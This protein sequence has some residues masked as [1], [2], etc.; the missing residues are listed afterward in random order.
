MNDPDQTQWSASASTSYPQMGGMAEDDFSTFLD[1]DNLDFDFP[2]HDE[3]ALDGG[4]IRQSN[5]V[6]DGTSAAQDFAGFSHYDTGPSSMSGQNDF[7]ENH[8][9]PTTTG[10]HQGN[11]ATNLQ[12]YP[13]Q[14]WRAQYQIHP[15]MSIPPTPNS[16][17]MYPTSYT[18][19][20]E[21]L[22]QHGEP[23]QTFNLLTPLTSPHF[24][25]GVGSGAVQGYVVPN[26][27]ILSPLN[28][29]A[30]Y[31]QLDSM[32]GS[33]SVHS[34][35]AESSATG[36]PTD[37]DHDFNGH[38]LSASEPPRKTRRKDSTSQHAQPS[39]TV[40]TR[41][42]KAAAAAAKAGS[43]PGTRTISTDELKSPLWNQ[44]S[45][46][47]VSS[48]R[49]YPSSVSPQF[50]TE[51]TMRPPPK[52]LS[53]KSTPS[54]TPQSATDT[55]PGPFP[56]ATP[57]SL[58]RLSSKQQA[59]NS[60]ESPSGAQASGLSTDVLGFG[61]EELHLPEAAATPPVP[62][63]VHGTSRI[64][65]SVPSSTRATPALLPR[66]SAA[67]P[68]AGAAS[69]PS[70]P[71]TNTSKNPNGRGGSRKRNSTFINLVSPAIR[72]RI[73]PNIKPIS[74]NDLPQSTTAQ[75][76]MSDETHALLL[77]SKSNY[78][79]LLEGNTLPG[80]TYPSELSHNL[81]SKRT[82]HKL[83]EQ[84]RRNRINTALQ[85]MQALLPASPALEATSPIPGHERDRA[86]RSSSKEKSGSGGEPK[87]PLTPA[88]QGANSKAAT[89]E[90]AI[91]HIRGL[92]GENERL[93]LEIDGLKRRLG[94]DGEVVPSVNENTNTRASAKASRKGGT[95]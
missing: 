68:A 12:D 29:P 91:E 87:T 49:S 48:V 9:Q 11:Y 14:H 8:M 52:P 47:S 73:S 40:V 67:S 43:R 7:M 82:S 76:Q 62:S 22:T 75:T 30:I 74:P 94:E 5:H 36:S 56:P 84:G 45:S 60:N 54:I 55:A 33:A 89:V 70:S 38:D 6:G 61:M 28:S 66:I 25:N 93:K 80:V 71:F 37:F 59:A 1:L 17:D 90:L 39:T 3:N 77:A 81:T 41:R 16:S 83:A 42:R 26:N 34:L 95:R 46:A 86:D 88:M 32:R 27:Q 15:H 10:N 53:T 92:T 44:P 35:T 85:E 63:S 4:T 23:R 72:P 51:T 2:M 21:H 78:Q 19:Q 65:S 13:S 69:M 58:M 18:Q 79:N 57:A 20:M 24:V 50:Q 64:P 31:P